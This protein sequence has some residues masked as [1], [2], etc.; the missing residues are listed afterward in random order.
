MGLTDEQYRKVMRTGWNLTPAIYDEVWTPVLRTYSEACV[1]RADLRAGQRVLD[2]ASGPGNAARVAARRV[3]PS[4]AVLGTDISDAFVEQASAAAAPDGTGWLRFERRAM[5]ELGL[6]SASFDAATC[7]LGLMYAAPVDAALGEIARVLVPGGKFAACVWGRRER[8]GFRAFFP[9]L[10]A[11]LQMDVCPLFFAL[12]APGAFADALRRAGF[13]G[14][15][16]E[17]VEVTLRWRDA[18]EACA[19]VFDGG[20]G[21][22]PYAAFPP[23]VRREICDEYVA[24]LAPYRVGE[25][26][27][28]PAEFVLATA[29]KAP[30]ACR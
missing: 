11:R 10:G 23:E 5:E 15:E 12:G 6:P 9:V 14:A 24:S 25:G 13:V 3:G 8:C 1:A 7:V 22:L 19:A 21:A 27:E 2:V 26:F 4:G 28:A 29:R 17:R 20:P 18:R 30:A 16:E